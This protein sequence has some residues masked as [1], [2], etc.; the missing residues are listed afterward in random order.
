MLL[1]VMR[2]MDVTGPRSVSREEICKASDLWAVD[3]KS[4]RKVTT[5]LQ[6]ASSFFYT[7]SK[8]FRF[9][10][11]LLTSATSPNASDLITKDFVD[12]V[13]ARG[14]STETTRSYRSRIR[15]FLNYALKGPI[16]SNQSTS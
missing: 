14:G 13:L 7:A 16:R 2:F 10:S 11:L 5:G 6:C 1:N 15:E 9:H 8:W 12:H 4:R 3:I